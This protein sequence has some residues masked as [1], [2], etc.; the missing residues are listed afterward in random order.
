VTLAPATFAPQTLAP[1]D[2]CASTFAPQKL[3]SNESNQSLILTT[4][5]FLKKYHQN[6]K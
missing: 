3:L 1:C 4:I 5:I 6:V 2:I